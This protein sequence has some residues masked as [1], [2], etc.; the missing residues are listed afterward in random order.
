M[1]TQS[2]VVPAP[3]HYLIP[4]SAVSWGDVCSDD[5]NGKKGGGG[6][7]S[8]S[9]SSAE[10]QSHDNGSHTW[11]CNDNHRHTYSSSY[12]THPTS[13]YDDSPP[14]DEEGQE[15]PMPEGVG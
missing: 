11:P 10:S 15:A 9:G 8:G 12:R 2:A 7:K 14:A 5:V 13:A 1:Y 6:S 3:Q 4:Y